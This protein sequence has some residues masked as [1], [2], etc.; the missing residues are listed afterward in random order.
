MKL[1]NYLFISFLVLGGMQLN[2]QQLVLDVPYVPTPQEV[3]DGMLELAD[4]KKGE[5]VYDI[6]DG[7]GRIVIIR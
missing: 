1:I 2:A 6:D 4:V 7:D 3:V 5:V